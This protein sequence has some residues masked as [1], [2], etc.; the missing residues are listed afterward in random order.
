MCEHS[1]KRSIMKFLVLLLTVLVVTGVACGQ[2]QTTFTAFAARQIF[3]SPD[4]PSN[5]PNDL[6][7]TYIIEAANDGDQVEIAFI[8]I[9]TERCCDYIIVRD[10]RNSNSPIIGNFRG[11]ITRD[12]TYISSFGALYIEFESDESITFTGF[13][14]EYRAHPGDSGCGDTIIINEVEE[15]SPT[16]ASPNYPSDYPDDV[17]CIWTLKAP[18]GMRVVIQITS[19]I[20]ESCCDSLLIR[21]GDNE[22]SPVLAYLRGRSFR[23][24]TY[25][26]TGQVMQ[27]RFRSNAQVSNT[28]FIAFYRNE[29]VIN[30]LTLEPPFIDQDCGG[31]L[32]TPTNGHGNFTSPNYPGAH[33]NDVMCTWIITAPHRRKVRIWFSY[34][35]TE[36]CC[37]WIIIRDGPSQR[38]AK[39]G[40]ISGYPFNFH[41]FVSTGPVLRVEFE[42]DYSLNG[43]GFVALYETYSVGGDTL[44]STCG[45]KLEANATLQYFSSPNFPEPYNQSDGCIWVIEAGFGLRVRLHVLGIITQGLAGILHIFDGESTDSPALLR[46]TGKHYQDFV[47]SSTGPF[48]TVYFQVAVNSTAH[49][50]GF[51]ASYQSVL[52]QSEPEN[53]V[54]TGLLQREQK[55]PR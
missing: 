48:M 15:T 37:D 32:T 3:S 39:L 33:A 34:V 54:G 4:Y 55:D 24:R 35:Y 50:G 28:G 40:V 7:C 23:S 19:Y 16:L 38:S 8:E 20:F 31:D 44:T 36:T 30:V 11:N 42:S 47:R 49:H 51:R 27:V 10:G 53:K 29:S 14:V 18:V 2:C 12:L 1:A 21:N 17:F 9:L 45:G 46:L 6:N 5:Y 43:R 26:S 22:S 25:S 52:A 13:Q 41:S